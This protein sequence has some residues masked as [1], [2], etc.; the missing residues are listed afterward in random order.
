MSRE[1]SK[2]KASIE[3]LHERLDAYMNKRGLRSTAQRRVIADIFFKSPKHVTIEELLAAVREV[4]PRVGYATVYRTLKLFAECGIAA[5][6]NFGDGQTR[7]ELS[8]ESTHTHHDHL[9]CVE[10][11]KI[12]EF[13]DERIEALQA[14]IARKFGFRITSHKHEVYGEC[15]DCQK[16]IAKEGRRS[17]PRSSRDGLPRN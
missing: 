7:Y 3:A 12:I 15:S 1:R 14:D 4:E 13:H 5:E 8:D 2:G 9:I 6:R 10:C 11:G 16:K 17:A